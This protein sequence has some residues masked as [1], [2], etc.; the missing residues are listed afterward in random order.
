MVLFPGVGCK[1]KNDLINQ[2]PGYILGPSNDINVFEKDD[3]RLALYDFSA[4]SVLVT[5]TLK[6][7]KVKFCSGTLILPAA[8][9]TFLRVITNHHCFAESENDEKSKQTLLK[10]SCVKTKIY[11]DFNKGNARDSKTADCAPGSLRSSYEM[12][13]AVFTLKDQLPN[14]YKPLGIFPGSVAELAGKSALIIHHPDV[15]T[16][17][18]SPG[19]GVPPLPVSAYTNN[20]CRVDGPFSASEAKLDRTLPFGI[21]HS[22]DLIH[23]SSGSALL[24]PQTGLILGVNWGGIQI[25]SGGGL[26]VSNVATSAPF[27]RAFLEQKSPETLL[28]KDGASPQGRSSDLGV[29]IAGGRAQTE[30]TSGDSAKN[31][32]K[33]AC[34]VVGWES[35]SPRSNLLNTMMLCLML[36]LPV[37]GPWARQYARARSQ[38]SPQRKR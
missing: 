10:E 12:D 34:G 9:E 3:P 23:G 22:C 25:N 20:D 28:T 8:N 27:V 29:A 1:Q 32:K 15:E 5:T 14:R 38:T 7:G 4:S 18:E 31:S 35:V 26:N 24:D 37:V 2:S 19:K 17:R 33:N 6:D 36:G 13:L 16:Q 30:E 21:R 11:L